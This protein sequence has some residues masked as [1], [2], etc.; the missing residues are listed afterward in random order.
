MGPFLTVYRPM[1]STYQSQNFQFQEAQALESLGKV[2]YLQTLPPQVSPNVLITNSNVVL[3]DLHFDPNH[4]QLI[5]HP[6]SGHDNLTPEFVIKLRPPIILGNPIRANAVATYTLSCFFHHFSFPPFST[7]WQPSRHWKRKVLSDIE[8]LIIGNGHIGKLI[9]S[10][11]KPLVKRISLY[12]P[13]KG[14]DSLPNLQSMDA[15][16]LCADLNKSSYHLID[17][18]FLNQLKNDVLIINGARG[19]LI[20]QNALTTFLTMNPSASAYLDVYENEPENF[21][22]FAGLSNIYLTSHL[23]GVFSGLDQNIIF[24]IKKVL[25][26]FL[27]LDQD[28]FMKIYQSVILQNKLKNLAEYY[29]KPE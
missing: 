6:N 13:P 2:R 1:V 24:F 5:I 18:E 9:H 29:L 22:L 11:L 8:V 27:S 17:E 10:S 25:E 20:H 12:D 23:A 28:Q 14:L 19:G 7:Q 4:C 21:N 3:E 16:C 15:I 26:D